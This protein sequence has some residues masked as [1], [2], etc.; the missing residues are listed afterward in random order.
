MTTNFKQIKMLISSDQHREIEVG[1]YDDEVFVVYYYYD[2]VAV[3]RSY[4]Y[5]VKSAMLEAEAY[6]KLP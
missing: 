5:S 3:D 6:A 1:T 2:G 4:H